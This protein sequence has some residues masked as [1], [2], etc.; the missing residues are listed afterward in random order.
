MAN[1]RAIKGLHIQSV[2]SDNATVQLGDI[3]YNTIARK[4]KVGKSTT[5]AWATGGNLNTARYA[6][7]GW[8][9]NTA[10]LTASGLPGFIA[11]SEE[12][13]GTSWAEGSNLNTGRSRSGSMGAG[14]QTAAMMSAGRTAG[15]VTNVEEYNGTS[16]SEVT[17]VPTAH[18]RTANIGTQTA[19]LQFGGRVASAP[20]PANA[21]NKTFEYDGTN[22]TEGG[23]IGSAAY[24]FMSFG[25]QT[26][27]LGT[28]GY[29]GPPAKGESWDYNG[30]AW[31]DISADLNTSRYDG[32][33]F[34][35]VSTA[36]IVFGGDK[37]P[38]VATEVEY[39]NGTSWT[40]VAD[41]N[42][43]NHQLGASGTYSSGLRIGGYQVP[44]ITNTTE[45]WTGEY[46]AAASVDTT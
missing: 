31:T 18:E 21:S 26:A 27:G 38:G 35:S 45:E 22:W 28:G 3:W 41:I 23:D 11:D 9:P 16:W 40:E 36:G 8:G 20:P 34:G 24:N 12:Y 6:N 17:D 14:T 1:Y 7:T 33:G 37:A 5:G 4:I 13:D 43:E 19:A 32:G 10:A 39:Y 15:N 30:T 42:T 44:A 25:T 29:D 2:S 46:V